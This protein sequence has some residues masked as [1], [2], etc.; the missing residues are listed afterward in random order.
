MGI[1][2]RAIS[3]HAVSFEEG[4]PG[5]LPSAFVMPILIP[6]RIH[7]VDHLILVEK[8]LYFPSPLLGDPGFRAATFLNSGSFMA[9]WI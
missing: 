1:Q 6:S 8:V 7:L 9:L 3:A 5:F 4:R 2:L